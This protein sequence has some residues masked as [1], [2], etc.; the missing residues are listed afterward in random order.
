MVWLNGAYANHL[1]LLHN[2][3]YT[4]W[5]GV[6]SAEQSEELKLELY[7]ILLI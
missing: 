4:V 5:L 2:L 7:S 6:E 3:I 1:K